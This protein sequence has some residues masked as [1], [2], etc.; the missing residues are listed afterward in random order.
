MRRP[1]KRD[2]STRGVPRFAF[3]SSVIPDGASVLDFGCHKGAFGKVLAPRRTVRYVGI[4][5]SQDAVR[6]A[7]AGLDVRNYSFPLPFADEEFDVVTMF[8]VLEHIK[9]QHRVLREVHRVLRPGGSLVVSVPRQHV[10]SFM[11]L[12]N[13]KFRLPRVHKWYYSR[14]RSP[15][16]YSVRYERSPDGL[17]GDVEVE[18]RWHQHFS[19]REMDELL[20]GA[21]FRL[22]EVDGVGLFAQP[23]GIIGY[24]LGGRV[25]WIRRL[26]EWDSYAFESSSLI[27]VAKK[28]A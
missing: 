23:L 20:A 15:Q 8:E 6:G 19:K 13:L 7:E 22:A 12:G 18:K 24:V 27:C 1:V 17:V 4:D 3:G 26:Q 5:K 21:G 28:V 10:F 2:D 11:D 25:E 14:T 9:D 16:A